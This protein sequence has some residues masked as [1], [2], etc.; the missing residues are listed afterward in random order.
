MGR[1]DF[2][3]LTPSNL[4]SLTLIQQSK[5]KNFPRE[6]FCPKPTKRHHGFSA[7]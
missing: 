1:I 2:A 7:S 4:D 5:I 3:S 6:S